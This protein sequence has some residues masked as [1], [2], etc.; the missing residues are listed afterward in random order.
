MPRPK[1][2]EAQEKDL[3]LRA[4]IEKNKV[5][6]GIHDNETLAK[7]LMVCPRTMYNKLDRPETLTL[8]ELRRLCSILHFTEEEK[9]A[10]M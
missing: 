9:K 7:K 5:L 8:E 4:L 2:T 6:L 3:L 10:I 1:K